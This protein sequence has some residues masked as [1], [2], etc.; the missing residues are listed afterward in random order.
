MLR[1]ITE[2][3]TATIASTK[4]ATPIHSGIQ[5]SAIRE[6]DCWETQPAITYATGDP[7]SRHSQLSMLT[8]AAAAAS[9][10]WRTE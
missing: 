5:D 2:L 4:P 1:L 9:T 3:A 6:G 7:I 8:G 10:S